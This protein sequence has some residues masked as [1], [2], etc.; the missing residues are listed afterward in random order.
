MMAGGREVASG[1]LA[2]VIGDRTALVVQGGDREA[3]YRALGAAGLAAVFEGDH[4]RLA[5]S[6]IETVCRALADAH[7]EARALKVPATLEETFVALAQ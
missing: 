4:L 1:S 6:D 7:L 5:N 3:A 2:D